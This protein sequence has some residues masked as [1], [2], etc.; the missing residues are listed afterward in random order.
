M[1]WLDTPVLDLTDD[2]IWQEIKSIFGQNMVR[3]AP[4]EQG[5]ITK[6][7]LDDYAV[8]GII[9]TQKLHVLY[10]RGPLVDDC[11]VTLFFTSIRRRP[12]AVY[13]MLRS[14]K[15]GATVLDFGCGVGSHGI[16][17]AQVG[18]DVTFLDISATMRQIT[19]ERLGLRGLDG[20]VVSDIMAVRGP[21]DV[22][23]AVDVLE[24][25][26][27]PVHMLSRLIDLT[28]LGY[29][30]ICIHFPPSVDHKRG[31]LKQAVDDWKANAGAVIKD[32]LR[33]ASATLDNIWRR[34]H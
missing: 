16:A 21:F 7:G 19:K 20:T 2:E 29:G 24:H 11:A 32:R 4:A 5:R 26:P 6:I 33:P 3:T 27:E 30:Q 31:H 15:A 17:A 18:A 12:M 34:I 1:T 14:I 25:L 13:S 22:V 28:A 8:D 23:L 10:D 9:D